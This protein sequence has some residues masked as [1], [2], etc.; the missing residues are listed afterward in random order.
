VRE[1][2]N[3]KRWRRTKKLHFY[4]QGWGGRHCANATSWPRIP[5]FWDHPSPRI[6]CNQCSKEGENGIREDI[7]EG[8]CQRIEDSPMSGIN[9]KNILQRSIHGPVH[10]KLARWP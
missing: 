9:V 8:I 2:E 4:R 1:K 6:Q 3:K 7:F 5:D 10:L